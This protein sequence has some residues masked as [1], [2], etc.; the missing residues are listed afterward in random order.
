MAIRHV[1]VACTLTYDERKK[2][3]DET[4]VKIGEP[5]IAV[6]DG[7]VTLSMRNDCNEQLGLFFVESDETSHVGQV[8]KTFRRTERIMSDVWADI[9]YAV[10]YEP[11]REHTGFDS[12]KVVDFRTMEKGPKGP[13]GTFR[14][15]PVGNSEFPGGSRHLTLVTVDAS[16]EIMEVYEAWEAGQTYAKAIRDYDRREYGIQQ[17]R[18]MI[19]KDRWVRVTRGRKV[20]QGTEGLVFW[21]GDSQWGKKVGIAIPES[22]NEDGEATFR[23]EK[24]TGRYGKVYDSYADVRW[25]YTKNCEVISGP[26]GRIL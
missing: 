12:T 26:G 10:V 2:L 8:V 14:H 23:K 24:R 22:V 1:S 20:K 17:D 9:T 6:K 25:T 11:S 18:R 19:D 4:G 5:R 16:P 3:Q 7:E 13:C 15:I 21:L